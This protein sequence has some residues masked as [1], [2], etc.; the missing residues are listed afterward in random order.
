MMLSSANYL[1]EIPPSKLPIANFITQ[2]TI[3]RVQKL[4]QSKSHSQLLPHLPH[5]HYL[6][7]LIY[8]PI[9]LYE[10]KRNPQKPT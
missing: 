1:F 5:L 4:T 2:S 3:H 8:I 6:V 10:L 9:I 7:H